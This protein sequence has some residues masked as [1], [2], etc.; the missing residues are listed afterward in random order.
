MRFHEFKADGSTLAVRTINRYADE[1]G[2]DSMDY[3]MFKKSA[4]LLDKQMLASLAK[5]I[6]DADTSPREYVMKVIAKR[7][8]DTFKK[9]Y[10]D[11][12]GYFSLMKPRKDLTDSEIR[13]GATFTGY[14]KDEQ[15]DVWTFPDEMETKTPHRSNFAA[16]EFLSRI[17]LDPNFEDNAPIPLDQFIKAT[18]AYME[19]NV[20]DKDTNEYDEVE[21]YDQ[22]AL[23]MKANHKEITHVQFS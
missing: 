13:E 1:I 10:G 22:E 15:R 18:R 11:Q 14:Y 3:D 4:E 12:D 16:R 19:K 20:A 21:M 17:G 9:M 7:D 5:H 6:N 2:K 8:P 23:R